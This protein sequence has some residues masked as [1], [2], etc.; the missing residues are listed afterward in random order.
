MSTPLRGSSCAYPVDLDKVYGCWLW[1][2]HVNNIGY[3]LVRPFGEAAHRAV[4][5]ALVGPIPEGLD[6][7]HLC[8]R[9]LCVR[10]EHLEPVTRRENALRRGRRGWGRR[11]RKTR[12]RAGHDLYEHGRT[13]PE[14]GK[15]CL[16]C[17][18]LGR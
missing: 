5:R 6:L 16:L 9:T 8:K 3:A 7:D 2:G 17:A 18:P 12:C 1:Q 4:Y 13:T 11:V 15:V 14:G 10:P